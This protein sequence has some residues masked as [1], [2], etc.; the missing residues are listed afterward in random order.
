M[1]LAKAILA[2]ACLMSGMS[3]AP[4]AK[5]TQLMSKD[6][7]NLPG[8]EGLMIMVEYPPGSTDP[9]HRHKCTWVHLCAG[10]L[11]CDAGERR[12]GDGCE[13]WPDLL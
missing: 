6:L 5:V 7:A 12:Q 10:R 1:T 4:E 11:D 8:K 13:S 2:L 9:I 3:M